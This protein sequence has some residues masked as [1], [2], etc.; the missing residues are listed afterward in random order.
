[1]N[2]LSIST[3][4]SANVKKIIKH[5]IANQDDIESVLLVEYG[6]SKYKVRTFHEVDFISEKSAN[7]VIS[8]LQMVSLPAYKLLYGSTGATMYVM[9]NNLHKY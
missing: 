7:Q 3:P 6:S 4:Y 8:H 5:L 9:P 2:K 1:M